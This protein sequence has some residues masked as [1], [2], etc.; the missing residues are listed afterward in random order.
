MNDN[1]AKLLE[2]LAAKLGTTTEYLWGILLKQAPISATVQ[3]VQTILII[4]AAVW[5]FKRHKKNLKSDY[6][7]SDELETVVP[8]VLGALVLLILL[9]AA[10]LCIETIFYGYFNPE[11][12]ALDKLLPKGK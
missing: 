9:I 3:L 12:W 2:Q 6:Y 10:L 5:L 4:L 1:T 7:D 8:M 11:Y